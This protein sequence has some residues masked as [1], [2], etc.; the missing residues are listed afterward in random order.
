M[1]FAAIDIGSNAVRLLI[2]HVY[3]TPKGVTFKKGEMIRLPIR[4]GED[5]FLLGKISDEKKQMLCDG[6]QAFANLIK[7]FKAQ[8]YMAC[9]TSA[10]RDAANGTEVVAL[11]KA[12]TGIDINIIDGKTEA[13]FIFSNHVEDELDPIKNYL[14]IDV[15]GGSTELTLLKGKEKMASKSFNVG[16]LRMLHKKLDDNVWDE[17]KNW[18]K[19]NCKSYKPL[20]GIGSGGNINRLIKLGNKKEGGALSYDKLKELHDMLQSYSYEDRMKIFGLNPDRADVIL[21][22]A[23]IFIS[24][25]KHA[26]I[27]KVLVPQVGLSDGI[28]H[29]LYD[30]HKI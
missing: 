27:E 28:I 29:Y 5:V 6:M 12:Q 14:Y 13:Q 2:S 25:M 10:M 9:A 16:T 21:P 1:I 22:A 3:N 26:E 20:I 11:V 30:K 17:F 19:A 18:I 4:L 8:D 7:I 15:G 24:A 23:K